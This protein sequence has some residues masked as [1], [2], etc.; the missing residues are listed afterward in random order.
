FIEEKDYSLAWH[1]RAADPES[2]PAQAQE[3]L[4]TLVDFTANAD[5]QILQGNKVIEV[6]NTGVNKG[7]TALRWLSNEYDFIVAFGDDWTDEDLFA[8]LPQ[9]AYSIKVRFDRS[10]ARFYLRSHNEVL[11][12]LEKM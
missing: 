8:V 4:D 12:L 6:R 1:Y 5:I 2:G 3:L 11:A 10:H 7:S 9:T